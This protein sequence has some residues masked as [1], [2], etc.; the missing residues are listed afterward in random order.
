M[1][2]WKINQKIKENAKANQK[3]INS[4]H[5][6]L[7]NTTLKAERRANDSVILQFDDHDTRRF[8]LLSMHM[9]NNRQLKYKTK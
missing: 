3:N 2:A 1:N 9:A 6:R 7:N 4:K 5:L 8:N